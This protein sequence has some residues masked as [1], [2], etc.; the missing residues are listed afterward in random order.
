[1][2]SELLDAPI[3]MEFPLNL[4]CKLHHTVEIGLHTE[5]IGEIMDVKVNEMCLGAD[6]LPDIKLIRPLLFSPEGR[7]YHGRETNRQGILLG[8]CSSSSKEG[9]GEGS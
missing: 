1:M 6:G 4:E 7:E 8:G 2:K 9:S 3:V 5:F